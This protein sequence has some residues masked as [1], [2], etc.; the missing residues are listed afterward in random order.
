MIGLGI[1]TLTLA[2]VLMVLMGVHAPYWLILVAGA[3][4]GFG[5]GACFNELQVKVQQDAERQDVP[6]A[7]SF[8]YLIRM[9]S[10]TFTAA[11]YGIIMNA[12]LRAGVVHSGGC[13][14]MAMLNKL[15]DAAS[16]GSLPQ[17]LLPAMRIILHHGL[18]NIMIV[19]L[20]LMLVSLVI[21]VFAEHRERHQA[22]IH[23]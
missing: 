8:S 16:V 1:I 4:E 23:I 19:A 22:A 21:N 14:T 15:S 5:N 20:V 3:F 12:A 2:F 18:H 7:T 9:L 10:Q 11:I 17:H 6:A 13:I